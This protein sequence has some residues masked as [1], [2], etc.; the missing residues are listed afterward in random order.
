MADFPTYEFKGDQIIAKN[1]DITITSGTDFTKI[2]ETADE[3]FN[4]LRS[5]KAHKARKQATHIVTPNGQKATILGHTSSIWDDEITVRFENGQIRHYATSQGEGAQ[6]Q[7]IAEVPVV[8]S[9]VSSLQEQLG[10]IYTP[11]KQ[12]LLSRLNQLEELSYTAKNLIIESKSLDEQNQLNKIALTA[13]H[14]KQEIKEALE[15]LTSLDAAIEAP[16]RAYAAVEQ[17]DL[18]RGDSWL[19]VVANEMITE[20][21]NRDYNKLLQEG[22]TVLVSSLD[23]GAIADTK[24]VRE[25]AIGDILS[26]TAGYIGQEVED[27]RDQYIAAVEVARRKE[28]SLRQHEFAKEA[29]IKEA[30]IEGATDE[31]LFL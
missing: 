24:T 21:D 16:K 26:K 14:E 22:P 9:K 20:S 12:G 13:N 3:Y 4:S 5:E 29:S 1:G 15:Y 31:A 23:D 17:A 7:Y 25:I 11:S 30:S 28:A 6:L 10:E 8:E 19:E 18:G 27:Y 2:A